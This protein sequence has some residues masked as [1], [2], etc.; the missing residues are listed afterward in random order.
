MT[1]LA[2]DLRKRSVQN[3][4]FL[5]PLLVVITLRMAALW[6]GRT[7]TLLNGPALN[8]LLNTAGLALV[9]FGLW[10][11]VLARGW[12]Y[13][14]SRGHLVTTGL[15]AFVRHPL[16]VASFLIGLG[17]CLILGDLL[18]LAVYLPL[19][20]LV[21][22][23][24]IHGEE[25]WLAQQWGDEYRLYAARVPRF[26]PRPG[27]R[28]R[29]ETVRPRHLTQAIAREADALC[30]WLC[31]AFLILGWESLA[32]GPDPLAVAPLALAA[33]CLILW[34]NLKRAAR[35]A[36]ANPSRPARS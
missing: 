28:P 16:Y 29:R 6:S 35:R 8:L 2:V 21:H 25:R 9:G 34:P 5:V 3:W 33:T 19:F 27:G 24:V 30:A 1:P 20:V 15:Y 14:N 36:Q 18:V 10:L 17:L 13:E 11:R 26:L 12:K 22:G 32:D 7:P 23:I 31:V 4:I